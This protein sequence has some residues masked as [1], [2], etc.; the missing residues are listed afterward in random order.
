MYEAWFWLILFYFTLFFVLKEFL[1]LSETKEKNMKLTQSD[2]NDAK[3]SPTT[4]SIIE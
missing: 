4:P 2:T 1:L 3:Q